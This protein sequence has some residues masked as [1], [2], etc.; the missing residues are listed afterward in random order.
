MPAHSQTLTKMQNFVNEQADLFQE[1]L[2]NLYDS[3][4]AE[5]VVKINEHMCDLLDDGV[6]G[7]EF[8]SAAIEMVKQTAKIL[9]TRLFHLIR[10]GHPVIAQDIF[11]RMTESPCEHNAVCVDADKQRIYLNREDNLRRKR[12]FWVAPIG[13]H[14]GVVHASLTETE[15][16]EMQKNRKVYFSMHEASLAVPRKVF[17]VDYSGDGS[18]DE[19]FLTE[20]EIAEKKKTETLYDTEEEARK[21]VRRLR[22][23]REMEQAIGEK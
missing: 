11:K 14:L 3:M 21:A 9:E 15:L 10:K 20:S 16:A 19:A 6:A 23:E 17:W 8:E 13:S 4:I 1:D 7:K 18:V 22:E 5:C 2:W 12:V